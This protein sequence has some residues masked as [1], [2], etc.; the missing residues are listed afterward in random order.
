MSIANNNHPTYVISAT[1]KCVIVESDFYVPFD[2][3]QAQWKGELL[4]YHDSQHQRNLRDRGYG[5]D[6]RVL[7]LNRKTAAGLG[8]SEPY[9]ASFELELCN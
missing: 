2:E 5:F 7:M 6:E 8:I 3:T 1:E 4:R 9:A